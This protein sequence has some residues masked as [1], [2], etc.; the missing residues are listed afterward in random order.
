MKLIFTSFLLSIIFFSCKDSEEP[1]Y[2]V[3][4]RVKG[5][6]RTHRISY[7]DKDGVLVVKDSVRDHWEYGFF[8]KKGAPLLLEAQNQDSTGSVITTI[9][10]N[11]NEYRTFTELNPYG[12]AKVEGSVE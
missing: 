5:T 6:S 3:M 10:I 7:K 1:I 12:T 8:G 11:G 4:Y 2:D 9:S